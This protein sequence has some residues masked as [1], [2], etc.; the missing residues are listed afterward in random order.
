MFRIGAG[1]ER[2]NSRITIGA[3]TAI[4]FASIGLI[5]GCPS[6]NDNGGNNNDDDGGMVTGPISFANDIQP[7]FSRS[8]VD[9][10]T[11]GGFAANTGLFLTEGTAFSRLVNVKSSQNSNLTRVVPGDSAASLLFQK[12]SSDRPPV[13]GRMPLFDDALSSDDIERIR[14]WI[15]EGAEEN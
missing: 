4:A 1:A 9:C 10:H 14:L 3:L 7:I 13:G 5:A 12:I 2:A 6:N 8:C 15:D 11:P